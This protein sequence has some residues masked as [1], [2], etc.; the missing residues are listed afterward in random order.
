MSKETYIKY[1]LIR[2]RHDMPVDDYL[3]DGVENV[4]DFSSIYYD[5]RKAIERIGS[6]KHME[7]YVTGLTAVVVELI[8]VCHEQGIA[9][10]LMHYDRDTGDYK[11]Q[12]VF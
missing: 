10:I 4:L 6:P 11:R 8:N 7:V 3:L 2:G 5:M 9:L 12:F 1:G